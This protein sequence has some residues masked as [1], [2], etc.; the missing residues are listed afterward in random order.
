MVVSRTSYTYLRAIVFERV[1]NN[2]INLLYTFHPTD[3]KINNNS[4]C[5]PA[6]AGDVFGHE[7]ELK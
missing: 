5:L 3:R 6:T 4:R 1:L 2:N 7:E